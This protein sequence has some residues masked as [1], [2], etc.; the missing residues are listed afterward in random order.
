MPETATGVVNYATASWVPHHTY[1]YLVRGAI[2]PLSLAEW[3][4]CTPH[5]LSLTLT[6][7]VTDRRRNNN[8]NNEADAHMDGDVN[9]L[10]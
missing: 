8:K 3:R 4:F 10:I 2:I 1:Y 9:Y 5:K 6:P 7:A